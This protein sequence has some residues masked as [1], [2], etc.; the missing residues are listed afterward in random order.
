MEEPDFESAMA[1]PAPTRQ[2][3]PVEIGNGELLPE[4]AAPL[5]TDIQPVLLSLV[6][7]EEKVKLLI[8]AAREIVVDDEEGRKKATE[9]GLQAK[10]MRLKVE[11]IKK[12]PLYTQAE[13]ILKTLRHVCNTLTEPL[14]LKVEGVCKDKL[15]AYSERLRLE[16]QRREAQAREEARQ[17]QAKLDQEAADL[18]AEAEGKA[19]AAAEELRQKEAAG[20]LTDSERAILQETVEAETEAAESIVAPKVVVHVEQPAN[21][22]R[23]DEGASFTKGRWIATL[24]ELSLVPPKYFNEAVLKEITKAAQKDADAGLR[25]IPGFTIEEKLSTSLRG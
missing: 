12:S 9:L 1:E 3:R 7:Y 14:K 13:D 19:K 23:T 11:T 22:T 10:K 15:T 25:N 24:T 17:L 18:K 21:V 6:P 4:I 16:Q 2:T 8:L 5:G 20:E